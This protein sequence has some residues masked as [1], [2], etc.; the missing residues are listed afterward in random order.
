MVLFP[1]NLALID[2]DRYKERIHFF[3][4]WIINCHLTD[5]LK[6]VKSHL[7]DILSWTVQ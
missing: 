4:Y 1:T 5:I 6:S 3:S 2:F 7:T